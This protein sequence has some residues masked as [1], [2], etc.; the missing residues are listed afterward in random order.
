MKV[1]Q[2]ENQLQN[3]YREEVLALEQTFKN[4]ETEDQAEIERLGVEEDT[5]PSKNIDVLSM[6]R[7]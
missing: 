1:E 5:V 3:D 2:G 4:K 6:R 7:L